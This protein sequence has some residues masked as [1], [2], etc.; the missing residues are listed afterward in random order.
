MSK[1]QDVNRLRVIAGACIDIASGLT[2][3]GAGTARVEDTV[4]HIGNSCGVPIESQ[5]TPTSVVVSVGED[6]AITRVCRIR[7]RTIDLDKLVELN[8]ISRQIS[9][10]ELTIHEAQTRIAKIIARSPR[11]SVSTIYW[12]QG[13]CCAGFSVILGGG[14]LELPSAFLEGLLAY[15]IMRK[16]AKQPMFLGAFICAIIT[17]LAAIIYN[18]AL[19][20]VM[21]QPTILAGIVPLLPGL[22]LANAVADLLGG[23]LTAGVARTTE[24][25][26]CAAALAAGVAV[27]LSVCDALGLY[28]EPLI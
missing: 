4:Q 27:S 1:P 6:Q 21:L 28:S 20:Q 16:T 10:H 11:Y 25:I 2:A 19:P 7:S 9:C 22:S 17:S 13:I 12:G 15:Y 24:A 18:F 23:D 14:L 26:L 5:V 8:D 3:V